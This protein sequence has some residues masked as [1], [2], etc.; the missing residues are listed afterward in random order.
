M[1]GFPSA[2]EGMFNIH[3]NVL[4]L[5]ISHLFI[6]WK[7]SVSWSHISDILESECCFSAKY[8]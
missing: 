3:M 4:P 5:H 8:F 1:P 6:S 7:A 2:M